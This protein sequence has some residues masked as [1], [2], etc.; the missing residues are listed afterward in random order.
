MVFLPEGA[1]KKK[2]KMK[3]GIKFLKTTDKQLR[4]FQYSAYHRSKNDGRCVGVTGDTVQETLN[5]TK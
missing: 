5:R 2:R 3:E 4:V 1:G